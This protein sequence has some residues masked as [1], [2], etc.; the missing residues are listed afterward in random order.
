MATKGG[1]IVTYLDELVPKSHM[2]VWSCGIPRSFDKL[3]PLYLH[4]HSVYSHQTWQ[5]GYLP[6]WALGY[7]VTS[8]FDHMVLWDNKLK[9]Y[10]STTKVRIATKLGEM[11]IYHASSHKVIW[12]F[13]HMVM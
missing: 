2:T 4:Y 3:K 5:D 6:G 13:D 9:S 11:V 1:S 7:K 12:L 8:S 10:I